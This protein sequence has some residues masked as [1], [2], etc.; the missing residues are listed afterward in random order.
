MKTGAELQEMADRAMAAY[1]QL[2]PELKARMWE[3]QRRSF[4]IGELMLE[5]PEMTRQQALDLYNRVS[6]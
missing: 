4:V 3:D 5:H 1:N 6:R 2:S